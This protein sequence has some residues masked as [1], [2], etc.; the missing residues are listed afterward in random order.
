VRFLQVPDHCEQ[1]YH[2]FPLLFPSLHDREQ[3]RARLRDADVHAA[4]HYLPLHLSKM[5]VGFGGRSGDCPVAES[6]S[7]R[8]LRLPLFTGLTEDEQTRAIDV[9]LEG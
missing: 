9:I 5:G 8:L 1:P 2:L 4:F 6:V 3:F 7:D